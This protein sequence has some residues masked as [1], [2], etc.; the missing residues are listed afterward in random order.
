MS[1]R[2]L[3]TGR[4]V[5]ERVVTNGELREFVDT[6]DDWITRRV[7]VRERRVCTTETTAQ[8]AYG[9]AAAALEMSGTAPGELDMILCAT[10][11][12]DDVCPPVACSVQGLLGASCPAMDISA[13]CSGFMYALE[14][15]ACFF[16]GRDAQKILV[17]GAERMSGLLDW[18]DRRTCVIFGDGAGAV[19]LGAGDGYLA[20]RLTARGGDGLIKIPGRRGSSPF[21]EVETEMPYVRMNGQETYRFAVNSFCADVAGVID[22]AGLTQNEITWVVPHQANIRIIEG[23][24]KR[25]S[26]PPERFCSNIDRYGNT[27]AASI[28][29]LLDEM[30]RDGRLKRD[31]IVALCSFGGGLTSAAC[32]IRW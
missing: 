29:I 15:A 14:T 26:I 32:V 25:L 17:I 21:Y 13:A 19:V 12:G 9:A 3:G 4:R 16:A 31:D 5:P 30:N 28:P 22:L 7:G 24:A 8:L 27:S 11:S 2:I 18:S 6:S 10:I 20:S 23:A 1:F